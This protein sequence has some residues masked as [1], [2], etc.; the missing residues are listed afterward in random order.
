M[1]VGVGVVTSVYHQVRAAIATSNAAAAA[2][3][4]IHWRCCAATAVWISENITL[5][6]AI[7]V[8]ENV[9]VFCLFL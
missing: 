3:L 4:L 9:E 8:P 6:R 2:A 1:I 5:Q 7:G